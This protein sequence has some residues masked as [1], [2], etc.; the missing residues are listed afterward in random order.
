MASQGEMITYY[1]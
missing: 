1:Y